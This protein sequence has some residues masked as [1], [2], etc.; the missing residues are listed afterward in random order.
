MCLTKGWNRY[1]SEAIPTA[2]QRE[3]KAREAGECTATHK[4]NNR[5]LIHHFMR[6][7]Y[8]TKTSGPAVFFNSGQPEINFL[9]ETI[10]THCIRAYGAQK[11]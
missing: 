5:V 10:S 3:I 1:S 11:A 6:E 9:G 8:C 2:P 7:R 4:A